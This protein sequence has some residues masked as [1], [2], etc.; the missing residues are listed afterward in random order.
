MVVLLLRQLKYCST[1]SVQSLSRLF[2]PCL[3][4]LSSFFS[5]KPTSERREGGRRSRLG[6][7]PPRSALAARIRCKTYALRITWWTEAPVGNPGI[8][9]IHWLS[10]ACGRLGK[11]NTAKLWLWQCFVAQMDSQAAHKII[12]ITGSRWQ[13]PPRFFICQITEPGACQ[14]NKGWENRVCW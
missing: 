14:A 2:S 1:V 10:L 13:R 7:A 12:A 8:G 4:Y 9:R 5:K 6:F 11:E 3:G